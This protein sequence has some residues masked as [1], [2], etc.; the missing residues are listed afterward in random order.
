MGV[1][2]LLCC[3]VNFFG[4]GIGGRTRRTR[5]EKRIFL[6]WLVFV[7]VAFGF[8]AVAFFGICVLPVTT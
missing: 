6:Y 4:G 7:S 8:V 3:Y 2:C 1:W 5:E